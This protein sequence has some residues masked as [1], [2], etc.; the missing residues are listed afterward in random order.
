MW[1]ARDKNNCIYLYTEKPI[2]GDTFFYLMSWKK[3]IRIDD[4]DKFPEITWENSPVEVEI[5]L[6]IKK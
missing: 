5:E 2:K 6:V 1:L 4:D 3:S